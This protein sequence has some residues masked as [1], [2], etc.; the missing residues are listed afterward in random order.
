MNKKFV[1]ISAIIIGQ[2]FREGRKNSQPPEVKQKL[3]EFHEHPERDPY[4]KHR[5]K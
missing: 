1:P 3:E 5:G 4:R 2:S